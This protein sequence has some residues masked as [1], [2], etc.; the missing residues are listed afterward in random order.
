MLQEISKFTN[1][2]FYS[3]IAAPRMRDIVCS[4]PLMYGSEINN[5]T[6]TFRHTCQMPSGSSH[7]LHGPLKILEIPMAPMP[8]PPPLAGLGP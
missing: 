2:T 4:H 1:N 6:D 8:I 5:Y 3:T 7:S